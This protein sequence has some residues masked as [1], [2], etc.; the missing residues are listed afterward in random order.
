[1]SGDPE[2]V[3]AEGLDI[4][5]RQGSAGITI[6]LLGEF[7]MSGTERFWAYVTEALAAGPRAIT[8]DASGLEF[9]DSAGLMAL[10]R[11]REAAIEAG[12][13]FR[14]SDP[15]PELRRI[16]ELCGLEDLL[17]SG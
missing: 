10:V 14:V 2:P 5:A 13:Q 7:D 3:E 17:S 11:A 12:V 4:E 15:S 6:V 9:V 8:V 1:M 16:A